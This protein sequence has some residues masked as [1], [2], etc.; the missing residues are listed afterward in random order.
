MNAAGSLS[1]LA[2]SCAVIRANCRRWRCS[3]GKRVK[4]RRNTKRV[5][6]RH[7]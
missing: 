4:A 5:G 3:T 7:G 2:E 1:L 6:N